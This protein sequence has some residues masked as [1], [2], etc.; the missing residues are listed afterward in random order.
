[1]GVPAGMEPKFTAMPYQQAMPGYAVPGMPGDMYAKTNSPYGSGGGGYRTSVFRPSYDAAM[2]S[3]YMPASSAPSP[4]PPNTRVVGYSPAVSPGYPPASV[5]PPNET[6]TST[7]A[8]VMS[9]SDDHH[10]VYKQSE[11]MGGKNY[12][13]QQQQQPHGETNHVKRPMNAFMV[14]SRGKRRQMAQE[15]PR[16]HNSEISKRLGAE[17]KCLT[18]DEKQPFIDEAK[19]L[20]A[21][22]IQE[23]P[24]DKYK[25]KRRKPK[26]I[27]KDLYPVYPPQQPGMRG[28]MVPAGMEPKFTAMPY[29]QAMPG[30]AVPGMPGDMYAKMNS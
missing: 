6:V 1:M 10:H 24:D 28:G 18:Q 25:P 8:G 14:W 23:H 3:N 29:Q 11:Y 26:T 4:P 15:N 2:Y 20:R 9:D 30:Y 22:H 17:W 27:K 7:G 5:A 21:V 19:R 12:Y 16:M 13:L